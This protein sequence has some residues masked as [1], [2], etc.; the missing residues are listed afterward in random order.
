MKLEL[1][2]TRSMSLRRYAYIGIFMLLGI[3]FLA[4]CSKSAVIS[5]KRVIAV[6]VLPQETFVKKVAGDLVDVVTLVPPG[7]SPENYQP[8]PKQMEDLAKASLYFTIGMPSETTNIIP[9]AASLNKGLEI[10]DLA[11][12]VDAVYPARFFD[13][14]EDEDHIGRDPH[15]WMSPRRAIVMV[16]A[17]AEKLSEIDP[18]HKDLY[19]SNAQAY[20]KELEDLDAQLTQTFAQ[21]EQKKFIIM[22]PSM[23]YFADDYGLTMVELEQNGKVSSASHMQTVIDYA[24]E[25]RIKVVFYQSEFDPNQAKT[26]AAEIDGTTMELEVL[27][28]DYIPN[29]KKILE[30]F[31]ANLK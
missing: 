9:G 24:R 28:A 15:M 23:G 21:I 13:A 26:L 6:T 10:I 31:A 18:K 19:N 8:T 2:K 17:I 30:I 20:I 25:N 12:K 5:D 7:A 14:S 27:S 22:H 11:A 3:L 4:G 1:M 29:M 16:N